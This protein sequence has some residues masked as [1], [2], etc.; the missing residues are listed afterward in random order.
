MHA[1]THTRLRTHTHARLRRWPPQA[2]GFCREHTG[3][4]TSIT[5]VTPRATWGLRRSQWCPPIWGQRGPAILLLTQ[6]AREGKCWVPESWPPHRAAPK[7]GGGEPQPVRLRWT[8]KTFKA[9]WHEPSLSLRGVPTGPG[10]EV[11]LGV[12]AR[13]PEQPGTGAQARRRLPRHRVLRCFA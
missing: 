11:G 8:G 5:P 4:T 3:A 13:C 2:P 7:A 9:G 1:H 6:L 12:R 10:D